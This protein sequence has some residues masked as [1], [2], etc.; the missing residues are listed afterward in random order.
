MKPARVLCLV[1]VLLSGCGD[2]QQRALTELQK[3]GYSLSVSEF[4]RAA[5]SGDEEA[6]DAFLRAGTNIDVPA[7]TGETALL[8]AIR[9]KQITTAKWL[10]EHG[11][12][13]TSN[14]PN[15]ESTLLRATQ[16]SSPELVLLVAR[17]HNDAQVTEAL[18]AAAKAGHTETLRALLKSTDTLNADASP[19][20]LVASKNGH[21]ECIDLLLQ[22]GADPDTRDTT[23]NWTP[24]HFAVKNNQHAATQLL[25]RNGASRFALTGDAQSVWQLAELTPVMAELLSRRDPNSPQLPRIAAAD[26]HGQLT[27]VRTHLT[28]LPLTFV[29]IDGRAAVLKMPDVSAE[30]HVRPGEIIADTDWQL[31]AVVT[32]ADAMPPWTLPHVILTNTRDGRH[33]ILIQNEQGI[34]PPI[35][36][37]LQVTGI[38]TSF[39]VRLGDT[40]AHFGIPN[41]VSAITRRKVLLQT[42]SG[43]ATTLVLTP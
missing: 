19:A 15:L 13:L 10:A 43:V 17:A 34:A 14:G 9:G 38:G 2:P 41:K 30:L 39:D 33:H 11:A 8:Q 36:A 42:E 35:S 24:L 1:A 12:K 40:F 29:S 20:L 26:I 28:P 4:H 7:K 31:K 18:L 37:T 22:A 5:E 25:L 32:E 23:N 6:L 16:Q 27:L 21:V 3:R